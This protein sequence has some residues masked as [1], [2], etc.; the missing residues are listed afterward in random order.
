VTPL[1]SFLRGGVGTIYNY[2]NTIP[3]IDKNVEE[4]RKDTDFLKQKAEQLDYRTEQVQ[5]SFVNIEDR[6]NL[7]DEKMD[8]M[9]TQNG[10]MVTK[11]SLVDAKCDNVG[12]GLDFFNNQ[13]YK[14]LSRSPNTFRERSG[15]A[16]SRKDR[17]GLRRCGPR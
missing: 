4:L 6:T 1:P 14:E 12:Q 13:E 9:I 3:R 2:F 11:V 16:T 10:G 5:N 15:Q 8:E 17:R 7:L